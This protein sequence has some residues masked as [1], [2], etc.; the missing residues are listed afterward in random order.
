MSSRSS[1]PVS[2]PSGLVKEIDALVKNGEFSSKSD[3]IR[4][5]VRLMVMMQ[6]RL[7]ERTEEYMYEDIYSGLKR[8]GRHV[9]RH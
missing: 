4:F 2:L 6:K 5:G 9:P 1:I 7:R 3:A 8:G